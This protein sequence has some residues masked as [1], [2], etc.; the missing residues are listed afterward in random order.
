VTVPIYH[1]DGTQFAFPA[2]EEKGIDVRNAID[3]IRMAHR[4]EY[5][6]A[7]LFSQDQD[8]SEVAK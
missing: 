5:D 2:G 4:A 3:V 1:P 6:I 8:L 7:I